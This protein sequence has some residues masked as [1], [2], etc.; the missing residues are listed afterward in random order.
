VLMRKRMHLD[1]PKMEGMSCSTRVPL[2]N[3]SRVE[4]YRI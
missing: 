1:S 2:M 4:E 3:V